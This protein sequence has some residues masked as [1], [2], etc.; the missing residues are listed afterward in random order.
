[1]RRIFFM[2]VVVVLFSVIVEAPHNPYGMMH[3]S[4][5]NTYMKGN[6]VYSYDKGS[7]LYTTQDT[8][9]GVFRALNPNTG[10]LS[11]IPTTNQCKCT[12]LVEQERLS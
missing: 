5:T 8:G 11:H 2:L 10:K 9:T 4:I 1:M 12:D 3:D 6:Y 7:G